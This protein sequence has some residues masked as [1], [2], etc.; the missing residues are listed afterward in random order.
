[1]RPSTMRPGGEAIRRSTES[2]VTLLPQPDS[3]TIAS[4]SPG[5]IA[6]DTPSTARTM[7]SR[8]KKCV[9][10]SSISSSGTSP[11]IALHAASKARVERIAHAV[12]QEIDRQ[13]RQGEKEAGKEDQVVG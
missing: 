10:R 6:K 9:L 5:M 7:P 13:D 11:A 12:T 3:P 4:V 2:E 8:V 1:M